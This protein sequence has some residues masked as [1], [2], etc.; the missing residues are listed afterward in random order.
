M[1]F[2][3][4]FSQLKRFTCHLRYYWSDFSGPQKS[5]HNCFESNLVF[6]FWQIELWIVD[7]KVYL[8]QD[9]QNQV[10][11]R[12]ITM[13]NV[14]CMRYFFLARNMCACV[15][16]KVGNSRYWRLKIYGKSDVKTGQLGGVAAAST[17][18]EQPR[19]PQTSLNPF[20]AQGRGW[21]TPG[22]DGETHKYEGAERNTG[23]KHIIEG[24]RRN[25]QAVRAKKVKHTRKWDWNTANWLS[26]HL[27][28]Q[29]TLVLHWTSQSHLACC[30][31][32][33]RADLKLLTFPPLP[34]EPTHVD[35]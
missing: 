19:I 11:G 1:R 2:Q 4:K 34:A 9:N 18:C 6:V 29:F 7:C 8:S 23:V 27:L 26:R 17:M 35:P 28:P 12:S 5:V 3:K 25:T 13:Y 22:E 15:W 21:N 32:C 30:V 14:Q 33:I 24:K 31:N 20:K 16:Y 10:R